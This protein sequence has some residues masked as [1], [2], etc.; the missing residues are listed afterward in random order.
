VLRPAGEDFDAYLAGAMAR[1]LRLAYLLT[2]NHADGEELVQESLSRVFLKWEK[3]SSMANRD[4]YIR[5]VIVNT[6]RRRF[7]RKRV[8][9]VFGAAVPEQGAAA[10]GTGALGTI[11]DR[12][13]LAR[14]WPP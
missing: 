10:I 13:Q 9:E 11:E 7:R 2:G 1:L 14:P 6:N 4:A 3:V 12:S 8:T 5:Q